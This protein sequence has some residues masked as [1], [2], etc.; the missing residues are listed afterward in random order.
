MRF[1]LTAF[2]PFDHT[3]LNSSLEG[4]RLFLERWGGEFDLR[5]AVLPVEYG[6]DVTAL[7]RVL[8]E[9][10]R[11]EGSA[12]VLLHTGQ[13]SSAHEIRVERLAVNER[14]GDG[15]RRDA[16]DRLPI[17]P[18]GPDRLFSTLPVEQIAEAIRSQGVPA[19]VSERAGI[20]LCNHVLYQSLRRVQRT[21]DRTQVGFL[22]IPCL[23]E[24]VGSSPPG[25]PAED[26]ARALRATLQY[27]ASRCRVVAG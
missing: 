22:H 12:E 23:P 6:A 14:Y 21:G 2:E 27:L 3:G 18:K 13:A 4:C 26:V 7:E 17:E 8:A 16:A 25:M 5:F 19:V 1:L 20:Y 10:S 15:S 11:A 9:G 24:Q